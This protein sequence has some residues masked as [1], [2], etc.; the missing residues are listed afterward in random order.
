MPMTRADEKRR[1]TLPDVTAGD[2]FEIRS[3][4]N[5]DFLLV[6]QPSP[7]SR[8]RMSRAECLDAMAKNPL[9]MR[10]NWA[11]IEVPRSAPTSNGP[12]G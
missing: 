6:R 5:G 1:V 3:P 4:G 2:V 8:A 11:V 10:L 12:L 7:A 9:K